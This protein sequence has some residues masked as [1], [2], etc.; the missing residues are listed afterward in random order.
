MFIKIRVA[1]YRPT[2]EEDTDNADGDGANAWLLDDSDNASASAVIDSFMV[3][4]ASIRTVL[5]LFVAT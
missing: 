2:D 5:A 1:S 4:P 3:R